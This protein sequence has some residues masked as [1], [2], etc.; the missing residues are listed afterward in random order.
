MPISK[1]IAATVRTL[2]RDAHGIRFLANAIDSVEEGLVDP[3]LVRDLLSDLTA[4]LERK[5][6]QEWPHALAR[7]CKGRT[8]N[9]SRRNGYLRASATRTTLGAQ[10]T[11]LMKA[12]DWFAY[13]Y[14]APLRSPA[15]LPPGLSE[16][17]CVRR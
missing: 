6:D 7:V 3:S 17:P 14:A 16:F 9:C 13:H 12:V 4:E 10:W 11:T 2:A 1:N 8:S 5:A 15:P